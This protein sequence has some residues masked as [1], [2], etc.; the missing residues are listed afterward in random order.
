MM[1]IGGNYEVSKQLFA[2][3]KKLFNGIKGFLESI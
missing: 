2:E 1:K 3:H